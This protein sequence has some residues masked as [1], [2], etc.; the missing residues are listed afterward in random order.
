MFPITNLL[1]WDSKRTQKYVHSMAQ[2]IDTIS[3][4]VN[5][6]RQA[7][8]GEFNCLLSKLEVDHDHVQLDCALS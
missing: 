8:L 6:G 3:S 5:I 1:D 4:V 7:Q 2:R